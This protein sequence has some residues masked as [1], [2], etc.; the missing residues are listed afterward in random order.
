MKTFKKKQFLSKSRKMAI[1]IFAVIFVFGTANAQT[2]QSKQKSFPAQVSIFYP[3]GTHGWESADYTYNFSLNLMH[4]KVGG[5]NGLEISGFV[6]RVYGNVYGTQVAGFVNTTE[7]VTGIQVAGLVNTSNNMNGIQVAGLVNT[8]NNV[9][10]TQIAGLVNASDDVIGIQVAGL[11][12]ASDTVGGIQIA[13]LVNAADVVKGIQIGGLLSLSRCLQGIQIGGLGNEACCVRGIQI[14]GLNIAC[15]Y[16]K[17]MQIALTNFADTVKGGL[18]IGTFNRTQTLRGLQIGLVSVNDT[19]ESGGSLSLVNIVRRGFYRSWEVSVA[20]YSN[21]AVTYRMGTRTLYTIYTVGANFI[22]DN[23]WNVGIG[24]GHRRAINNNLDFRPEI[25]SYNY[26]PM[27]FRNIQ[28]TFSTH[29]KFGFV[30]NVSENFGISLTPSVFALNSRRNSDTEHYRVSPISP[31]YTREKNN[32]Q[33][34]IGAGI[35]LGINF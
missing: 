20:D 15:N 34:A 16:L 13:G 30:Y 35:S 28:S 27:D 22:E 31:F 8:T 12:N 32:W 29:L 5:I 26:F 7:N 3:L 4:G 1:V 11:V 23:L 9:I 19:I 21:L 10:G 24:F 14:G 6:G 17:G 2:E 33:T 18:Q 25:V